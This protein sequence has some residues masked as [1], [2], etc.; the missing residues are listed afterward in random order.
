MSISIIT[1]SYSGEKEGAL[2]QLTSG[3]TGPL[4]TAFVWNNSVQILIPQLA[5][6]LSSG[7]S[8]QTY[9]IRSSEGAAWQCDI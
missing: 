5:A 4:L 6:Q 7:D 3:R 8:P 9:W 2:H 1:L